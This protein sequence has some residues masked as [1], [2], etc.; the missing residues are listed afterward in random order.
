[1]PWI[2]QDKCIQCGLCVPSCPV[3][4]IYVK[5]GKYYIDD[6]KCTHCGKC[7]E[8]CPVEAI[9][10]NFEHP[11][12]KRCSGCNCGSGRGGHGNHGHHSN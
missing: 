2:K 11:D 8:A 3:D 9:R 4:A 5:D 10:P 1:M 7:E 12:R 6:K